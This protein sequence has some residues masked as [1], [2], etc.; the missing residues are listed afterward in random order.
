MNAKKK[1]PKGQAAIE[2]ILVLIVTVSI[3][4]ALFF[5]MRQSVFELWVCY[6]GPRIQSP[7]GC[8][9]IEECWKSLKDNSDP[10]YPKKVQDICPKF[11]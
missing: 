2:Y 10:D 3:F 4:S 9:S 1:S 11:D 7:G 5:A 8:V 6:L